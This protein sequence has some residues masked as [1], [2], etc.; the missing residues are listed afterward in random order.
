MDFFLNWLWW[1]TLSKTNV[2]ENAVDFSILKKSRFQIVSDYV[3][4]LTEA[5]DKNYFLEHNVGAFRHLTIEE[6]FL[7]LTKVK[8][9]SVFKLQVKIFREEITN[10]TIH[11][12][13][14]FKAMKTRGS[15][16]C[17]IGPLLKIPSFLLTNSS[18]IIIIS[19]HVLI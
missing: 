17:M 11:H 19:R 14:N 1:K 15:A 7:R 13:L 5:Q 16:R 10:E 12:N 4:C 6:S 8:S 2:Q 18:E 3:P 9:S